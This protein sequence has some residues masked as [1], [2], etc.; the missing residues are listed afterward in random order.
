VLLETVARARYAP[1]GP[2]CID[3]L[4]GCGGASLGMIDSAPLAGAKMVPIDPAGA[5]RNYPF[6]P[7]F[8][9]DGP[10]F[11]LQLSCSPNSVPF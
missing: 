4:C 1:R 11:R 7:P 2:V 10:L 5:R 9:R 6:L 8:V 3:L